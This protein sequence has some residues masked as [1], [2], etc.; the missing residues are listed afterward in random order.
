[1]YVYISGTG[2]VRQSEEMGECS[3]GN[4]DTNPNTA[5]FR[6]DV[7]QVPLA[8]P[9]LAKIVSSPR[10][11][12]DAKTGAANGL[13]KGGN[14]GE[15][16][17]SSSEPNRCHDVPVYTAVGLA[18]GACSGNGILLDISNPVNPVR[19]DAVSDPNYAF[20]HSA[21]FNNAGTKVL[22]TDEWG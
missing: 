5:L 10:I 1:I 4:P 8:H 21:T 22:F 6:I 20:W 2:A 9:E 13:W 7:I 14:Y 18:A 17:Q 3:G 11:F 16:S 19:L 12:A 15:G